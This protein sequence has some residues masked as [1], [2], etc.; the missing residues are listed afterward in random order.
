MGPFNRNVITDADVER[1]NTATSP[2][3]LPATFDT[4]PPAGNGPG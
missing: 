4:R 1:L 3:E 2:S